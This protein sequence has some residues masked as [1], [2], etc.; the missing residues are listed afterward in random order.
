MTGCGPRVH[1]LPLGSLNEKYDSRERGCT[2]EVLLYDIPIDRK[3]DEIGTCKA[4]YQAYSGKS[5]EKLVNSLKDCACDLGG[6]AIVFPIGNDSY[7]YDY[8]GQVTRFETSATVLYM[9]ESDYMHGYDDPT[10][11]DLDQDYYEGQG[12]IYRKKNKNNDKNNEEYGTD[13]NE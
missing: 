4:T 3:S 12:F 6:N 8:L 5:Y 7:Q 10:I 2:M 9:H 11:E 1:L 13:E